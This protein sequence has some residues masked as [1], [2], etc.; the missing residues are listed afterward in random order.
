MKRY[1]FVLTMFLSF[2]CFAQ[3]LF[4]ASASLT[5]LPVLEGR[6][7]KYIGMD[8]D[9]NI[10]FSTSALVGVNYK[11]I[12]AE[13]E[14]IANM[15]KSKSFMFQ[16]YTQEYYTRVGFKKGLVKIQWE[17]LCLHS[18]DGRGVNGGHDEIS[19]TFD[20]RGFK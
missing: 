11:G 20:T 6:D 14:T 3:D 7:K 10:F 13:A 17:H 19:I 5:Y 18:V 9:G 2:S 12:F 4:Y 1:L 8:L 15:Y 16:P